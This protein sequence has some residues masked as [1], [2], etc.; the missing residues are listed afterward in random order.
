MCTPICLRC[1]RRGS[2]P[3]DNTT[4]YQATISN[5]NVFAQCQWK[6]S[7]G[8]HELRLVVAVE[9][10]TGFA[11]FDFNRTNDPIEFCRSIA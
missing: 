8:Q 11:S 2:L 6:E 10:G 5:D 1:G 7:L 4:E 3:L 9:G